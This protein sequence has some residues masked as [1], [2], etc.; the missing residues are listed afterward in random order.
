VDGRGHAAVAELLSRPLRVCTVGAGFFSRFHHD[1]WQRQERALLVGVCDVDRGKAEAM[2]Q[3]FGVGRAFDD[4]AAMLDACQPDLLDIVTPPATHAAL[5]GLAAAR[6]IDVVCQKPLAPTLAEARALAEHAREAGIR[7]I[8]HENFR[9]QPW[10]RET[11]RLLQ[12]GVLGTPHS[13]G[14]RLRPGDG[15]GPDAYLARQPYFQAMARF[16][17]HE[18]AIHFIDTFRFLLGEVEA[19]FAWLRR[20]NPAIAGEDAGCILFRFASGAAGLFDGNRL[21]E[22]ASDDPRRTMGEMWLEGSAGVL[23]LDGAGRLWWKPHG[24]AERGHAYAFEDRN[25]GGDCVYLLQQHVVRH[26]QGSA[27]LEN[28]A[29]SYLRNIVIEEAVYRSAEEGRWVAIASEG[30]EP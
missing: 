30:R 11:L 4:A 8:V 2:A 26:L 22:H 5:V 3:A 21:N 23:R 6:G 25:F 10:Y 19:V 12:R 1:A 17:V 20:L 15:Q 13:I 29:A 24:G 28:D 27:P 14:F 9:F 18:T 16:L 7:L